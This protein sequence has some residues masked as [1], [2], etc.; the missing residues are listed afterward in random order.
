MPQHWFS[1]E[2]MMGIDVDFIR[3]CHQKDAK[4]N[5]PPEHPKGHEVT[6]PLFLMNETLAVVDTKDAP[7]RFPPKGGL[8]TPRGRERAQYTAFGYQ[9]QG[10]TQLQ[11][12]VPHQVQVFGETAHLQ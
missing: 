7:P 1:L 11:R 3:L 9:F 12:A 10:L 6:W 5:F 8:T 4:G 2:A